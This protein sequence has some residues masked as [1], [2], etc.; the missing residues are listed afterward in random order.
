MATMK[1]K[2]AWKKNIKKAQKARWGAKPYSHKLPK[3]ASKGRRV[4]A[5]ISRVSTPLDRIKTLI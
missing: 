5:P 4:H 1:Q 2:A 3:S